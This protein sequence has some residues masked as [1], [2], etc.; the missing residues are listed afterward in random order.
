MN[1]REDIYVLDTIKRYSTVYTIKEESVASH[2]FFVAALVLDLH[3][4]YEFDLGGALGIAICHDMPEIELNDIPR[5]IKLKYPE[6]NRLLKKHEDDIIKE[7]PIAVRRFLKW[8]KNSPNSTESLIVK[9]ADT[10]QCIQFAENEIKLGNKGYMLEVVSKSYE[11]IRK[12]EEKLNVR[13][14][15]NA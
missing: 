7:M 10:L 3:S 8:Y 15:N 14:R 2:S 13:K 6:L 12:L 5:P 1:F 4:T 9:L 11:I